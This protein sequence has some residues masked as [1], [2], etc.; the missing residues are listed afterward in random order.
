[1]SM[2]RAIVIGAGV[3]ALSNS[4]QAIAIHAPPIQFID[5]FTPVDVVELDG[6]GDSF[7]YSH[8]V[9]P[10][11]AGTNS[12]LAYIDNVLTPGAGYES[13]TD[14]LTEGTLTL[15]FS[16][17]THVPCTNGSFELLLGGSGQGDLGFAASVMLGNSALDVALID[18]DGLLSVSLTRT[19][20]AGSTHLTSAVLNVF[21]NRGEKLGAIAAAVPEPA[22]LGLLA[23][24]LL[25]LGL[26]SHRR[27]R[28]A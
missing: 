12:L 9:T 7:S 27:R 1:M 19:N 6:V 4:A 24:G 18:L 16:S 10:P 22:A 2:L 14:T 5:T 25:G 15:Y 28:M 26:V 21:G 8:D 13:A 11:S 17:C 20:A 3:V 23:F